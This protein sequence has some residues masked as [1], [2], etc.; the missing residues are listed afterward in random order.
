LTERR[1]GKQHIQHFL[2]LA[3][4]RLTAGG[5]KQGLASQTESPGRY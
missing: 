3:G 1:T 5:N 2:K 4:K